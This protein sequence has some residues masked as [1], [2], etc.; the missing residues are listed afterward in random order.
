[1]RPSGR[2]RTTTGF[3]GGWPG[4][5]PAPDITALLAVVFLTWTLQFF[6]ATAP[7]PALLRL[8]PAVWR[9]GFL[10][11]LLTYPFV[12][13]GPASPWILLELL[14]VLWFGQDVRARLGRRRF[15]TLLATVAVAAAVA[16][17][18]VQLVLTAAG[19]A[20]APFPFQLMQ[21]QRALLAILVAAFA[22]LYGDATILLFFVLPMPARWFL[23]LEIGLAFVAY[24]A[25]KDLAGFVGICAAVGV[26]VL[27]LPG[28]PARLRLRRRYLSW[29][30]R[31]IER[32]LARLARRRGMRVVRR[33]DDR[34][35]GPVN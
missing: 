5:R 12:G 28:S 24:L 29:R 16:A 13:F 14:I 25:S 34:G 33:D 6:A 18:L 3:G 30:A 15:W 19:G 8:T 17:A 23:W 7:L 31:R 2:Y 1:V 11:Q 22:T 32:R 35:D 20:A 26:T 9:F 27:T 4:G 21:G 10:W